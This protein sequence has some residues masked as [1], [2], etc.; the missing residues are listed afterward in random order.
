MRLFEPDF[1]IVSDVELEA[2]IAAD[3][4]PGVLA[5]DPNVGDIENTFEVNGNAAALP[6]GGNGKRAPVPTDAA[7]MVRHGERIIGGYIPCVRKMDFRPRRVAVF[8]ALRMDEFR[9][10]GCAGRSLSLERQSSFSDTRVRRATPPWGRRRLNNRHRQQ[11]D[12]QALN[13]DPELL[14]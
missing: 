11:R 5:V 6:F 8:G 9:F 13:N 7:E 12:R 4:L 10:F 2:G 3:M 1:K 14:F